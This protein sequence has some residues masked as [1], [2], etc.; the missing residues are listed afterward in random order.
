MFTEKDLQLFDSKGISVQ[1]IETQIQNFKEGF[2][3][4]DLVRP[5]TP[6]DGI[7]VPAKGPQPRIMQF[8]AESGATSG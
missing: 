6:D 1:T 3:F 7:K 4:A 8:S 5:A 2:P